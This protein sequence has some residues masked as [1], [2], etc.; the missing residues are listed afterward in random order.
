L[1]TSNEDFANLNEEYEQAAR[2]LSS[3]KIIP[4]PSVNF[5]FIVIQTVVIIAFGV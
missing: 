2:P 1:I 3:L 4:S 5:S